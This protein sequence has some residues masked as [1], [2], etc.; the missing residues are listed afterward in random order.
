MLNHKTNPAD[1]FDQYLG[2]YKLNSNREMWL[3]K[4]NG[5]IFLSSTRGKYKIYPVSDTQ[6]IVREYEMEY[7]VG[8]DANGNYLFSFNNGGR[9][10]QAKQIHD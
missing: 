2:K 8:I 4:E 10:F 9:E 5:E 3:I 1:L 7:S 6:F